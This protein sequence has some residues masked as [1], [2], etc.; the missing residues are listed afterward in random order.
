MEM[1]TT[2]K[3]IAKK[4]GLSVATVSLALNKKEH[5]LS[6]KTIAVVR[7][8]ARE[9]NYRPNQIAVGLIT[10]RTKT[11]GLIVPDICNQFFAE[12]AKGAE[13]QC[14]EYGYNV[15]LCNTNDHPDKDLDYMD[16]LLDR[17]VDGIIFA[18]SANMGAGRV[19]RCRRL[20]E[21]SQTPVV[22]VDRAI[23]EFP[24]DSVLIDHELGGYLATR[25]L[26]ELGHRSVGCITGPMSVQ[27]A[28]QRFFGYIRALQEYQIPFYPDRIV[29]GDYHT[30]SGYGQA[31]KLIEKRVTALFACNDLMA[32]GAY[33]RISEMGLRIPEDMSIV[34][35]DDTSLSDIIMIPL[36]TIRQPIYE[37][38]GTAVT[39]LLKKIGEPELKQ[40]SIV[41]KPELVIRHSTLAPSPEHGAL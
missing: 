40:E 1:R 32:Y 16:V 18:M 27:T 8:A 36:T 38:G 13:A 35:F 33:K 28:K 24:V 2:L 15:I 5:R 20:I 30:L 29:E 25:H 23:D 19:Q 22:L 26:L 39:R 12:I 6:E 9:L 34:G 11:I 3:D 7:D 37:M 10:Q 17:G 14:Q 4:T 21:Q 31:G 41:F